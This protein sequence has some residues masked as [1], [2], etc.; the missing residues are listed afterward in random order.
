MGRHQAGEGVVLKGR[1]DLRDNDAEHVLVWSGV[2]TAALILATAIALS[3]FKPKVDQGSDARPPD[4]GTGWVGYNEA[5]TRA[6]CVWPGSEP[7][8]VAAD[9]IVEGRF[10]GRSDPTGSHSLDPA[11]F[12]VDVYR[13]GHGPSAL[14]VIVARSPQEA[15]GGAV[16]PTPGERWTLVGFWKGPASIQPSRCMGFYQLDR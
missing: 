3:V 2:V 4:E 10:H 7:A 16:D 11:P 9:V 12:V 13:K 14:S 8:R 6:D 15:N 1:A 5:D